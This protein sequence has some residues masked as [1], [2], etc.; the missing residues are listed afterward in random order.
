MTT[1][2]RSVRLVPELRSVHLVR[3]LE[4]TPA[5]L[6][7]VKRNYD[8]GDQVVPRGIEEVT[9]GSAL[10][11]LWRSNAVVLE[12]PE[13]LWMRF[14]PKTLAFGL[15]WKISG[16]L[17]GKR[18]ELVSYCM[19]NNDFSRLVGGDRRAPRALVAVARLVIGTYIR[20]AVDRL[21]FATA[22][23]RRLYATLPFVDVDAFPIFTELSVAR[24]SV[25]SSTAGRVLF[26]GALEA[27]KGLQPLM[28]AWEAIESQSAGRVLTIVGQGELGQEVSAWAETR[29]Q[30]RR[31]FGLRSRDD[32]LD[33]MEES[34]VLVAPSIPAGRWREQV[35]LPIKEAL[36]T[37][38]TVVTTEQTGLA[39]WLRSH[40]HHV[41]STRSTSSL[42]D[43]LGEA[44]MLADRHPLAPSDVKE[45][46]PAIESRYAADA[47]MHAEARP[48]VTVQIVN[49]LGKALAH[50]TEALA[51][52]LRQADQLVVVH[53]FFEPSAT[54]SGK[55][56]WVKAYVRTVRSAARAARQ[57]GSPVLVTWPVLGF[58]DNIIL[59]MIARSSPTYI[60]VHDPDPLVSAVGHAP[61]IRKAAARLG[62]RIG[63]IVHSR[64]AREVVRDYGFSRVT[65]LLPHPIAV[66]SAG[67]DGTEDLPGIDETSALSARPVIRVLGQYKPDR[68]LDLL[69]RLGIL[70]ARHH[71]LEVVGRGWPA[72]P[73]W[74]VRDEFVSEA[75][76]DDLIMSSSAVLIPYKRFF[77]SGIAIRCIELDTAVVGPRSSSLAD[78]Y[79][80]GA[81]WLVDGDSMSDEAAWAAAVEVA[82]SSASRD[83]RA[84]RVAITKAVEGAW[85]TWISAVA[86]KGRN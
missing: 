69:G 75:E 64:T 30:S 5:R 53:S 1:E 2:P 20:L 56:S 46:L 15:V 39:P 10:W 7:Y 40:G 80:T 50:Y 3:H 23:A 70:L 22:D 17:R 81:R 78:L 74:L 8:L 58:F 34:R 67:P 72:I 60:V 11:L 55:L 14:F 25:T 54:T 49:P 43:S 45:S 6:L 65:S 66:G 47:W 41:L 71:D 37:G 59:S 42:V 35:G 76:L 9:V 19:E 73:G 83:H 52:H 77:Q 86:E 4:T 38:L 12:L 24:D 85:A 79:P 26:V 18:R 62:R 48:R 36:S 16:V 29:P 44:L 82:V 32:V 63:V 28:R 27:R 84:N 13:P 33:L 21:A 61:A 51:H 57:D 68:D 31:F